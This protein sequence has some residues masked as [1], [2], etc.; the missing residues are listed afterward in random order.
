MRHVDYGRTNDALLVRRLI[1]LIF[2]TGT[3]DLLSTPP[4]A[5]PSLFCAPLRSEKSGVYRRTTFAHAALE[6]WPWRLVGSIKI[7]EKTLSRATHGGHELSRVGR[8]QHVGGADSVR[9][10]LQHG[11]GESR[12]HQRDH[13]RAHGFATQGQLETVARPE[14]NF[15]DEQRGTGFSE[16]GLRVHEL[17]GGDHAEARGEQR[18]RK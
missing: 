7:R 11:I 5:V 18:R 14:P 17:I 10:P 6:R 8:F 13:V 12:G 3:F 15:G 4:R 9:L 1:Q 2:L 16:H